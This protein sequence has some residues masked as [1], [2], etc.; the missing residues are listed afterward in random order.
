MASS[1]S[2]ALAKR[3]IR[4]ARMMSYVIFV[5]LAASKILFAKD[6]IEIPMS[7]FNG[8]IYEADNN[9]ASITK[10]LI[11]RTMSSSEIP[12]VI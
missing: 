12:I 1:S 4:V 5:A 2:S 6:A 3:R 7:L 9:D 10:V 11:V 8:M